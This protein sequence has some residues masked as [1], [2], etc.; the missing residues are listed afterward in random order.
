MSVNLPH[1]F[2]DNAANRRQYRRIFIRFPLWWMKDVKTNVAVAG[3]GIELSGG[4]LQFLLHETIPTPG[5]TVLFTIKERRILA[6][7]EIKMAAE[8]V[9]EKQLWQHCRAKFHGLREIDFHFIMNITKQ[10]ASKPLPTYDTLPVKI[11]NDIVNALVDMKRLAQPTKN[12]LPLL[13][14]HYA[15][16]ESVN[17]SAPLLK[18]NI[19]TKL[20]TYRGVMVFDTYFLLSEDG[21]TL[22]IRD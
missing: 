5:C 15:G 12:E 17:S 13:D 21:T 11:K 7:I 10:L 2:S 3:I 19:R 6:N 4:G 14:V 8:I 9:H 20:T 18:F 16:T 1:N 22:I